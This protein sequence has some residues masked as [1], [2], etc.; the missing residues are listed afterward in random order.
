M[1]GYKCPPI[2]TFPSTSKLTN[3]KSGWLALKDD[4]LRS[5]LSHL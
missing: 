1:S 2:V 4:F 5:H 3:V